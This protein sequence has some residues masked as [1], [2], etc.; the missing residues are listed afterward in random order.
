MRP[1]AAWR[2]AMPAAGR[3]AMKITAI[4]TIQLGEFPNLVWVQVHTDEGLT[5]LGEAFFGAGAVA[6]YVHE[7]AAPK[8]LGQD[9]RAIDRHSRTQHDT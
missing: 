6:A 2:A 8:Q 9:P 7:S 1:P 5:G 4:E 3:Q